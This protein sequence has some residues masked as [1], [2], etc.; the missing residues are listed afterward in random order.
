MK[1]PSTHS[2]PQMYLKLKPGQWRIAMLYRSVPQRN[3]DQ[4]EHH[5]EVCNNIESLSCEC[6]KI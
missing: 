3:K 5:R 6:W 4:A 2:V 1:E